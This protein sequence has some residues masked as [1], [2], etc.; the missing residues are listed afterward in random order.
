MPHYIHV[1]NEPESV[2]DLKHENYLVKEYCKRE[3]IDLYC[4]VDDSIGY[5]GDFHLYLLFF[6]S[7]V[8]KCTS[9]MYYQ[10]PL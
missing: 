7:F 3:G 9:G 8:Q 4:I 6:L 10:H 1:I 5:V 2:E